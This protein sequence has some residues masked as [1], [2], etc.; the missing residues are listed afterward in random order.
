MKK[1]TFTL[2]I[3]AVNGMAAFA[4]LDTNHTTT[5]NY[6]L[7]AGYSSNM[8]K[9]AEFTTRDPYGPED[10]LYPKNN[11]TTVWKQIWKK[12]DAT[13]FEDENATWHDIKMETRLSDF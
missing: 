11:P 6:F 12:I 4:N 1:I 3:L 13:A 9:Y 5:K 10:E 8:A 2:L 7:N